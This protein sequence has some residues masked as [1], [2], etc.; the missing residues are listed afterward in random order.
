MLRLQ[1]NQD[2]V[3]FTDAWWGRLCASPELMNAWLRKLQ[4]TELEGYYDNLSSIVRYRAHGT[5]VGTLLQRTALDEKRHADILAEVCGGRGLE[6]LTENRSPFWSQ[7]DRLCVDLPSMSA[8]YYLGEALAAF[9][10]ERILAHPGTPA[11]V[12]EFV[13][14]ALPDEEYHARAFLMNT[15]DDSLLRAKAEYER[16]VGAMRGHK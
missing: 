8:V 12:R 3:A 7:M 4:H 1:F 9:R 5:P 15:T 16:V 10:F 6:L 14:A 11:D 2:D 13:N